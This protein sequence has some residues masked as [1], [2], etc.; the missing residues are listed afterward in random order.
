MTER[1]PIA[2]RFVERARH[3]VLHVLIGAGVY[4]VPD[5][6]VQWLHSPDVLS[7][8]VLWIG[9]LT[10]LP[11][12]I[13]AVAWYLLMQRPPH[14]R[15]AVGLPLCMLLG[16]WMFGPLAMAVGMAPSGG[17]FLEAKQIDSFFKMWLLFPITTPMMATYSGSLGG[18]CLT[19]LWLLG[20]ATLAVWRKACNLCRQV[21]V[22]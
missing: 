3:Y 5:T 4:W 14:V 12:T 16:I 18:L 17:R 7:P 1:A 15:Y 13:V 19:S 9:L 21:N 11:S 2:V 20:S 8:D 6:L 10:V 22:A